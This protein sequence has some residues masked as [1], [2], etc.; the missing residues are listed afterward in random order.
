VSR[1]P[2]TLLGFDFG[3]KRIGVAVGQTL[4]GTATA[5]TTV[6]MHRQKPDWPAITRLVE[7]WQPDALVVGIPLTMTDQEQPMTQRARAFA[8]RLEGRYHLPVHGI[9]E[10]LST[11][12]ARDHRQSSYNVDSEAARIILE[13]WLSDHRQN[14]SHH[15]NLSSPHKD[16]GE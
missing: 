16:Q 15:I 6:A 1:E 8:R 12:A 5:L 4:T 9:D 2:R 11:R 3:D 7:E 10:R 13:T 14:H